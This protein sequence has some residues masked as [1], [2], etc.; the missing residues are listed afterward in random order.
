MGR[1]KRGEPSVLAAL[2]YKVAHILA[3]QQVVA[4]CPFCGSGDI[5]ADSDQTVH[6]SFC[7]RAFVVME[8]PEHP[9]TPA[10]P[11]ASAPGILPGSDQPDPMDPNADGGG[12][13]SQM[14]HPGAQPGGSPGGP[15]P[16]KTTPAAPHNPQTDPKALQSAPPFKMGDGKKT[17]ALF[18]ARPFHT[19]AGVAVTEDEFVAH[20]AWL[21]ARDELNA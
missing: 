9:A 20:L 8:Q 4:H 2:A 3:D 7:N 17:S 11:G 15:V 21:Y 5:I 18:R 10:I 16:D 1:K 12:D 6:C 19:A 14:A 13:P